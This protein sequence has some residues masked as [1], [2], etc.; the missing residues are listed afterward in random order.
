MTTRHTHAVYDA[1]VRARLLVFTT[2]G[3]AEAVEWVQRRRTVAEIHDNRS[4]VN[5][6]AAW[7]QNDSS[8]VLATQP[9]PAKCISTPATT[10]LTWHLS[11]RTPMVDVDTTAS[12]DTHSAYRDGAAP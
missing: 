1:A 10:A 8:I 11:Y 5:S 7:E 12:A 3:A 4:P 9:P 2:A 6:R